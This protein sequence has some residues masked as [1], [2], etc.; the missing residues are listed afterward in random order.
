MSK[1]L[2]PET[3]PVKRASQEKSPMVEIVPF[4]NLPLA[5]SPFY[6]ERSLPPIHYIVPNFFEL[7][8]GVDTSIQDTATQQRIYS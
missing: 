6:F 8:S 7:L 5:L 4:Q 2:S 3:S 1:E